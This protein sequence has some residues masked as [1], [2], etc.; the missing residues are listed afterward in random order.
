M[1]ESNLY[2]GKQPFDKPENLMYGISI[3]DCCVGFKET[4]IMLQKLNNSIN[5]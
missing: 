4:T 5:T 2:E 1:I 3:T